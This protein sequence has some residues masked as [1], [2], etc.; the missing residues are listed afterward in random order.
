MLVLT[1][2]TYCKD[3]QL[4]WLEGH[5]RP[6]LADRLTDLFGGTEFIAPDVL[7]RKTNA[8]A[9]KKQIL[10]RQ[11]PQRSVSGGPYLLI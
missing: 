6:R 8:G 11:V 3:R 1:E 9:P 10:S 5:V 4:I 7:F 2:I